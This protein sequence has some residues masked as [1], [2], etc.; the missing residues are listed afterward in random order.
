M[1][2]EKKS[3]KLTGQTQLYLC[4]NQLHVSAIIA[5]IRLNLER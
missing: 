3:Y 1:S 4:Q 5:I 2:G